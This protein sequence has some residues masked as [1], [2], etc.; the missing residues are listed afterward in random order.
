M[1]CLC[2]FLLSCF[3]LPGGASGADLFSPKDKVVLIGS[4]LIEREQKYGY[5]ETA[6]TV[7]YPGIQFRNLGWSGDDITGHARRRF[8]HNDQNI[9]RRRLVEL[10]L[11]EKPTVILIA[12]GNNDSFAG[13]AGL[14]PFLETYNKLLDELAPAKAKVVL[15]TPCPS[16]TKGQFAELAKTQ[17]K[18]KAIYAK[19]IRELAKQ[20]KLVVADLFTQLGGELA[21]GV[22]NATD[23]SIHLSETGYEITT[24]AWLNVLGIANNDGYSAQWDEVRKLV[25]EKNE[26]YFHRWRPQNEPYLFGFRRHEQGRN[27]KEIVEF[28]P[29]I[30]AVEQKIVAALKK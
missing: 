25:V 13:E 18:N 20:R 24:S 26:L 27:A 23:N 21:S 1:R 14:N 12:Y 5:W 22:V 17:N 28:D 3:L 29:L 2:W 11:A 30:A 16:E 4:T 6:L 19:A 9:G 15:M 10:T 7:R 8:E